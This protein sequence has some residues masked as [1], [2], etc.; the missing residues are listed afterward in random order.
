MLDCPG[1][2]STSFPDILYVSC[3]DV[4]I[5]VLKLIKTRIRNR[6]KEKTLD[7]LLRVAIEGPAVEDFPIREAVALWARKKNR[8]LLATST[9]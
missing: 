5:E 1:V 9:L 3:R 7:S 2:C 8:K 4:F 6:M